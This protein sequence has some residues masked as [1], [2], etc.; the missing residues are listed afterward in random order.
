MTSFERA[1]TLISSIALVLQ[2]LSVLIQFQQYVE[3]P[4]LESLLI[5]NIQ[6]EAKSK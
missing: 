4:Q 5:P 6:V 1:C 3:P 2:L